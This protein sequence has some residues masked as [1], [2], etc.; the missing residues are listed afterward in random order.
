MSSRGPSR[1]HGSDVQGEGQCL[2]GAKHEET[3]DESSRHDR[4]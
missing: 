4:R 2:C 3:G 1:L